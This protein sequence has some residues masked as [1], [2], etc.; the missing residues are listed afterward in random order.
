MAIETTSLTNPM[1]QPINQL[2][3]NDRNVSISENRFGTKFILKKLLI[4][5]NAIFNVHRNSLRLNQNGH[6]NKKDTLEYTPLS[7][8]CHATELQIWGGLNLQPDFQEGG[9]VA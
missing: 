4:E 8:K 9:G 3:Y 2:T 6:S 1:F 7:S 5:P